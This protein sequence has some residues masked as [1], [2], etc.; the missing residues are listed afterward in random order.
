MIDPIDIANYY[1]ACDIAVVPSKCQEAAGNVVIEALACGIPVISTTKGGIPEYADKKASIL[2]DVN[3][4]FVDNLVNAIL[5]L[6]K[7]DS[8]Y[9]LLASN[10]RSVALQY[11]KHK[12]YEKFLSEVNKMVNKK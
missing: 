11:D 8:L 10:A 7:D 1:C 2:V 9:N 5:V 12:Y 3:D 6:I 4:C